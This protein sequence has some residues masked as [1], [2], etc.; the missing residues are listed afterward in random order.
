MNNSENNQVNGIELQTDNEDEETDESSSGETDVSS[1]SSQ[2]RI[3]RRFFTIEPTDNS[4]IINYV[5]DTK[6]ELLI[7][8]IPDKILLIAALYGIARRSYILTK[9]HKELPDVKKELFKFFDDISAGKWH[10]ELTTALGRSTNVETLPIAVKELLETKRFTEVE[11]AVAYYDGLSKQEQSDLRRQA[12]LNS[13]LRKK[14]EE[15]G[16]Q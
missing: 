13:Q 5:D 15:I 2:T 7:G 9:K 8:E 4:L 3:R 6:V 16:K 12:K 11:E 10:D 1:T 14:L